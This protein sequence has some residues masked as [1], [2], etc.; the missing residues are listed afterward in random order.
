MFSIEITQIAQFEAWKQVR[1]GGSKHASH[2]EFGA[3]MKRQIT[4]R[5]VSNFFL[6]QPA[7]F[8]YSPVRRT[9][10]WPNHGLLNLTA[11]S[12]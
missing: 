12:N 9:C 11:Q 7:A 10:F 5:E 3:E 2:S 4:L 6:S 8:P 1:R